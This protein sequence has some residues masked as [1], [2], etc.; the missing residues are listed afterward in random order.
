MVKVWFTHLREEFLKNYFVM[1][2]G[3]G[4][5]VLQAHLDGVA[6]RAFNTWFQ[7][8]DVDPIKRLWVGFF[9]REEFLPGVKISKNWI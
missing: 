5:K 6:R 1:F 9:C 8:V 3:I 2:I 4:H 7:H